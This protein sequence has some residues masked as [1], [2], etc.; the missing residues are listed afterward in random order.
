[1]KMIIETFVTII[2]LSIAVVLVSQ[3]IGSQV[4]INQAN[5]FHINAVQIIEESN[6]DNEV[7]E[8]CISEAETLGY[9]LGVE[10]S[11]LNSQKCVACNHILEESEEGVCQVCGSENTYT[12]SVNKNG[13]VTLDYVVDMALLG[14]SQEGYLEANAR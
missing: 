10:V 5:D 7:I 6:F 13:V 3:V 9:N 4:T 1:M 8:A 2:F 14:I 11:Y 12:Y